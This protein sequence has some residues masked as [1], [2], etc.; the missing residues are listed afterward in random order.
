M[1]LIGRLGYLFRG[2]LL[3]FSKKII[4][5]LCRAQWQSTVAMQSIYLNREERRRLGDAGIG[6][7]VY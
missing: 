1:E 2:H 7:T 6:N 4:N 5:L 3:P